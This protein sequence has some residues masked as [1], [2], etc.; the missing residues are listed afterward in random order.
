MAKKKAEN[1]IK[2]DFDSGIK[3]LRYLAAKHKIELKEVIK[4]L[5]K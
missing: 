4:Q 3:N 1:K 2:K 5:K